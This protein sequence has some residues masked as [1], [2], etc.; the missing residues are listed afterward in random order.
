MARKPYKP[1][2]SINSMTTRQLRQYISDQ[3]DEAQKRLTSAIGMDTSKAFRDAAFFITSKPGKVRR[4]TSYM[5]KAEM[6]EFAYDLR[7]FNSL[8]RESKYSESIDWK[9][10]KQKYESFIRNRWEAHDPYWE[11]YRTAKG[12]V[13]RTGFKEY[14]DFIKF[15]VSIQEYKEY[16]TYRTLIQYAE[17]ALESKKISLDELTTIISKTYFESKNKGY[18][19]KELIDALDNNIQDYLGSNKKPKSRPKKTATP[20]YQRGKKSSSNVSIKKGRKMK[21]SGK[22]RRRIT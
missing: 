2:Q 11:K 13:S 15:V 1:D 14:K 8:D 19:Q 17:D 22:V 5:S 20:T 10:N 7:N 21:E 3:A 6:V 12:N 18:S 16:F 9:E 4:S